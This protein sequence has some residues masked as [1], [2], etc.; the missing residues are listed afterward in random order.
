[1]ERFGTNRGRRGFTLIELLVVI[2]IIAL[3]VAI[4]LPALAQARKV[5]KLTREL[6]AGHDFMNAQAMYSAESKDRIMP[7]GLAWPWAH[8]WGGAERFWMTPSD[9][10]TNNPN[11]YVE[12]GAVKVWTWVFY[13]GTGVSPTAIQIDPA[14]YEE[15]NRRPVQTV[16]TG[17]NDVGITSR[18]AAYAAHPTFAM[19]GSYVGGAL[20]FGAFQGTNG[21]ELVRKPH[22]INQFSAAQ[23]SSNL[24]FAASA[25]SGDIA[26][27]PTG[28]YWNWWAQAP[29]TGKV[30]PGSPFVMAP[31]PGPG[32]ASGWSTGQPTAAGA[33]GPPGA[34]WSNNK[35][36]PRAAPST[37]GLMDFRHLDKA[38]VCYMDNHVE[39]EGIEDVRDMRKW[40]NYATSANWT[41]AP[42]P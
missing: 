33:A 23:N 37:W 40:S 31:S 28:I 36:D 25:R 15:F 38:V 24:I 5:A 10:Y 41:Y 19:N 12:G 39:A 9:Y 1:M 8:H 20:R 7:A 29:N 34:W 13:A 4:L 18:Q 27:D 21:A 3:L 30:R 14:T 2:A 26:T 35:F 32:S 22:Y 6:A 11:I 42:R 16:T 17:G